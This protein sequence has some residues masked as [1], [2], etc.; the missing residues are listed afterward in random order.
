MRTVQNMNTLCEQSARFRIVTAG[1][2]DI[3]HWDLNGQYVILY[4]T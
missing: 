3:C 2:M 1:G 4:F